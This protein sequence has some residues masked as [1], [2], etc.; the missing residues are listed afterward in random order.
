MSSRS[1]GPDLAFL[2]CCPGWVGGP[3]GP[4]QA[5]THVLHT[6]PSWGLLDFS[7]QGWGCLG[8][9]TVPQQL[10]G[11]RQACGFTSRGSPW[12]FCNRYLGSSPQAPHRAECPLGGWCGQVYPAC[13]S[14]FLWQEVLQVHPH[15][16]LRGAELQGGREPGVTAQHHDGPEEVLQPPLPLPCGRCGR[17]PWLPLWPP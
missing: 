11:Q 14:S 16:E 1:E 6:L 7:D 12:S 4:A 17:S 15:A 3:F 5:S 10:A 13:L 9:C 8:P 2:G